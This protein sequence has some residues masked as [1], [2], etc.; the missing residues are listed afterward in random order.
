MLQCIFLITSDIKGF[1]CKK[2]NSV[3]IL[4]HGE[5][6][7]VGE[8]IAFIRKKN[9]KKRRFNLITRLFVKTNNIYTFAFEKKIVKGG[10][11]LPKSS[12][13]ALRTL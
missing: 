9:G 12:N 3:A 2:F 10:Y 4:L 6:Q 11:H 5:N 13:Y 1:L 7:G 8:N